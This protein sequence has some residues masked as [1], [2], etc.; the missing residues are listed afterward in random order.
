MRKF[1][2]AASAATMTV[3]VVMPA[4]VLAQ[5]YHGRVWHD[6]YGRLRCSRPNGTT[7]L[8]IGGAAGALVG[9]A[10]THSPTGLI[11]GAAGG[12]LLGRSI[13]RNGRYRCR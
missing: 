8:I 3:P 11:V 1:L 2:L 4:P 9:Q 12:A 13:E 10:I 5:G 6:R 7:G